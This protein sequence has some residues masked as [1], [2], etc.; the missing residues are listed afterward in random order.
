[1]GDR[2]HALHTRRGLGLSTPSGESFRA[3]AAWFW[4]GPPATMRVQLDWPRWERAVDEALFGLDDETVPTDLV[5]DT[6]VVVEARLGPDVGAIVPDDEAS[7]R[8]RLADPSDPLA[9]TESWRATEV[10]Q[11]GRLPD[12]T[13]LTEAVFDT[14]DDGVADS[15]E[16]RL[17]QVRPGVRVVE[18]EGDEGD[19]ESGVSDGSAKDGAGGTADRATADFSDLVAD[20]VGT[21]KGELSPALRPVV[22]ALDEGAGP[23]RWPPTGHESRWQ[24]NSTGR[25]GSYTSNPPGPPSGVRPRRSIPTDSPTRSATHSPPTSW[26]TTR[27]SRTGG[28]NSA[29]QGK[30]GFARR[31]SRGRIPSAMCSVTTRRRWPS[32]TTVSSGD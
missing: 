20:A 25:R 21:A 8:T 27:A 17:R 2:H 24:P 10:R 3:E 26:R 16:F 11:Q 32:G 30:S 18:R 29:K 19:A 12:A 9:Q 14:D 15:R 22:G 1:M 23:T 7:L 5:P 13:D 28:S 6:D 4:A 31:L